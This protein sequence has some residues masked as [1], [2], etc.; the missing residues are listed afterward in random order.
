M[1]GFARM[2]DVVSIFWEFTKDLSE[3]GL[4]SGEL[5]HGG[6]NGVFNARLQRSQSVCEHN[7]ERKTKDGKVA[8]Y[9]RAKLKHSLSSGCL[10]VEKQPSADRYS[11][12]A[13]L[14]GSSLKPL[15]RNT[16]T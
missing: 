13:P 1:A 14:A 16:C 5:L 10:M 8:Y 3:I 7:S 15:A 9:V 11:S 4:S 12:N 6:K 2:N